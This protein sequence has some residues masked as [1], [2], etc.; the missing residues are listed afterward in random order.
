ML[1]IIRSAFALC[2]VAAIASGCGAGHAIGAAPGRPGLQARRRPLSLPTYVIVMVQENRSVDNL[3]QTQ[4]GVDTQNFGIDSQHQRVQL[5]QI[6]LGA[7]WD[8]NHSHTAFVSE[9]TE[10]FDQ[11]NC[12]K[13]APRDIAFSYVNPS[14]ITQYTE[15]A[16][17]YAFADHV[18]QSNEGPTFPA[19]LCLIAATS[20]TTGSH[21]NIS[22][23]DGRHTNVAQDNGHPVGCNSP[24]GRSDTTMTICSACSISAARQGNSHG[25]P[26]GTSRSK[27]SSTA[28]RI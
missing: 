17:Q 8:C 15:L 13:N 6:A 27:A 11:V 10:G 12:G 5:T 19:H 4:P 3:F 16:T 23:N 24:V 2:A 25:F 28:L 9:V 1:R 18:L 7:S 21:W 26:P 22:E 20:V 14:D